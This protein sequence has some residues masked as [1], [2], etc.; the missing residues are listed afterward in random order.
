MAKVTNEQ[1]LL[2]RQNAMNY[3]KPY[4]GKFSPFLFTLEKAMKKTEKLERKYNQQ[5]QEINR[6]FA[7]KDKEGFYLKEENGAYKIKAEDEPK[8]DEEVRVLLETEVEIEPCITTKLMED[9]PKD[10]DF[11]WWSVLSPFV[12]PE[13]T[14]EILEA[15]YERD[16]KK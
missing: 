11:Q 6:S 12:L 13:I 4:G 7:A 16:K 5:V 8:R 2:F 9:L 15:L 3:R 10:I 14:D 1:V